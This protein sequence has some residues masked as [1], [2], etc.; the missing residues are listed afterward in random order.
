M[1]PGVLQPEEARGPDHRRHF[2]GYKEQ[3]IHL[4]LWV[5]TVS[6]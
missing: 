1:D 5:Y 4:L 6:V 2:A 3:V